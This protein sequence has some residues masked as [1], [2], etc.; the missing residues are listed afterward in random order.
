[1]IKMHE[2]E[3]SNYL[4]YLGKAVLLLYLVLLF[5]HRIVA[6]VNEFHMFLAF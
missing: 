5:A 2:I 1:M 3:I 4:L 6:P